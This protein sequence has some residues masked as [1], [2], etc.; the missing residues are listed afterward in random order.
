MLIEV[1]GDRAVSE[2]YVTVTL[3]TPAD[4]DGKV[5]EIVAR[6]RYLDKWSVQAGRDGQA[7]WGIDS[8]EHVLDMHSLITV[9]PGEVAAVSRRDSRDPSFKL[10]S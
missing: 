10:F 6:G 2:S 5:L 1:S 3:W 7:R 4:A 8:R 9:T